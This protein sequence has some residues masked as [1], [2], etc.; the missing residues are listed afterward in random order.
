MKVCCDNGK[1]LTGMSDLDKLACN[2]DKCLGAIEV[3]E[4]ELLESHPYP[5]ESPE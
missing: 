1:P 5:E 3:E 2:H 4:L